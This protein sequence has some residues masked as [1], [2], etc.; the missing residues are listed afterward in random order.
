MGWRVRGPRR[1]VREPGLRGA[2]SL[3]LLAG[4]FASAFGCASTPQVPAR[5]SLDP[6]RVDTSSP[7][8]DS[9]PIGLEE[10][11]RRVAANH[12][13]LRAAHARWRAAAL[14]V[15]GSQRVPAAQ[16][17]YTAFLSPVETRVGPQRQRLS[18]RQV[19]PWP[20]EL[21]GP[22]DAAQ[23][24][25]EAAARAFDALVLSLRAEVA[26]LYWRAWEAEARADLHSEVLSLL[27]TMAEAALAAREVGVGRP[28]D[29]HALEIA[30]TEL[31]DEQAQWRSR[32]EELRQELAILVGVAGAPLALD[33]TSAPEER[34]EAPPALALLLPRLGE[35]PDVL[36][37]VARAE[38]QRARARTER[39]ARWPRLSFGLEWIET[40]GLEVGGGP[41]QDSGR[42]PVALG[43]GL[44]IPWSAAA[45]RARAEGA[46]ALAE[47]AL[48]RG[49]ARE[50][51]LARAVARVRRTIEESGRQLVLTEG[52]LLPQVGSAREAEL[53][54][55]TTGQG[56]VG[57]V[58][59]WARRELALRE[60]VI[61]LRATHAVAWA[62]LDALVLNPIPAADE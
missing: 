8:S 41:V 20:A 13:G 51:E 49:E 10:L 30:R 38:A 26:G 16:L 60:R 27:E 25:V 14:G 47:A 15:R 50:L 12:P 57:A 11:V 23:A 35:H 3:L 32:A 6:L 9:G 58:L 2:G 53:A 48:A 40:G 24:E 39:A 1:H 29:V 45:A 52:T 56:S 34:R 22:R 59:G 31:V 61:A 36:G 55:L 37:A 44:S 19:V 21:T 62:E 54:A 17:S 7:H 46:E 4:A 33:L 43:M 5:A 18:L 42:D 28:S